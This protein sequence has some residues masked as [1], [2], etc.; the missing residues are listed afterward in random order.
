MTDLGKI[1]NFLG[2]EVLQ[3]LDGIHIS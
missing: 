1:K 2:V 3:G